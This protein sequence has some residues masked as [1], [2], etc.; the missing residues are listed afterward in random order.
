MEIEL[1]HK[2]LQKTEKILL[3]ESID[4]TDLKS[5]AR[6]L[7]AGIKALAAEAG[8]DLS[9][10]EIKRWNIQKKLVPPERQG[11]GVPFGTQYL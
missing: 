1:V 2:A 10:K 9:T 6:M 5:R 11:F 7:K 8:V 4:E 3:R